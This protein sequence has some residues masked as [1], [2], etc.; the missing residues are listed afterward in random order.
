L[1]VFDVTDPA[2][3][4]EPS[5]DEYLVAV[6]RQLF[7]SDGEHARAVLVAFNLFGDADDHIKKDSA[8]F[9]RE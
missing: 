3:Q 4:T 6:A 9:S 1:F 2:T 5:L 7:D 8:S